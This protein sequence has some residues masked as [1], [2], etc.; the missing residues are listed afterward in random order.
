[1]QPHD[2]TWLMPRS[3]SEIEISLDIMPTI[4]IGN[5]V[6]R[7]L[8]AV[9]DEEVV[10]LALADVDA[11]AAAADDDAGVRLADPQA[12]RRSTLRARR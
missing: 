1:M 9:L 7:D 12:R 6:G 2:S 3:R 4:E 8:P 11:A 10:V 5:G